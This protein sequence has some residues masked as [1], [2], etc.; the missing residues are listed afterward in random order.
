MIPVW[1]WDGRIG[2]YV[3]IFMPWYAALMLP[4]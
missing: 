4:Q 1:Y 2:G 3:Q